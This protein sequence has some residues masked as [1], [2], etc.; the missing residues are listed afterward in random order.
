[1]AAMGGSGLSAITF[2]APGATIM[3]ATVQTQPLSGEANWAWISVEVFRM[4]ADQTV[5]ADTLWTAQITL[6]A[7][8][9]SRPFRVL[10]EEFEVYQT[11]GDPPEQ[12]RLVYP[13]VMRRPEKVWTAPIPGGALRRT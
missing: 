7:P 13:M 11:G 3:V 5:G 10:I 1:M 2:D 12:T 4:Q 9:G 6:P 8:R